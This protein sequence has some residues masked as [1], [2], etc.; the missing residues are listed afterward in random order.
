M[1]VRF[2]TK[3]AIYDGS[4]DTVRVPIVDDNKLIVFAIARETIMRSLWRGDG[5]P[6]CLIDVYRRHRRALHALALHKY[7]SRQLEADGSVLITPGDLGRVNSRSI[8]GGYA[9]N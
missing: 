6:D 7:L 5:P 4:T 1:A 3:S 8:S 2:H 9:L